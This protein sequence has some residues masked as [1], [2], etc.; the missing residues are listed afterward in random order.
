MFIDDHDNVPYL[1]ESLSWDLRNDEITVQMLSLPASSISVD[2][3]GLEEGVTD[4]STGHTQGNPSSGGGGGGGSTVS[5]SNLLTTGSRIGTLT[6]NGTS[7]DIKSSVV[8]LSN[9]LTSGDRILTISLNGSDYDV[10]APQ[11][12]LV[13][14]RNRLETG[15]RIAT[16]QINNSFYDLYA[17]SGGSV[18]ISDLISNGFLI[19]VLTIGTTSYNIKIPVPDVSIGGT[20]GAPTVAVAVGSGNSGSVALPVATATKAGIVS[21][22]AQTFGGYKT[23]SRIYLGNSEARGAYLEWDDT[24]RAW[25]LVGDVYA[26]GDVAAG[27]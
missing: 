2:S 22:G 17:P 16:L 18:G 6:I 14:V 5:I 25:K 23:F 15:T 19:G 10:M 20:D 24:R 12:S 4:N 3:E 7:Y 1:V 21:T 26:T 9:R 8:A 13:S 11:Y 27:G